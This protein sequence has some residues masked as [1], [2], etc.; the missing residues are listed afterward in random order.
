MKSL[1]AWWRRCFGRAT[2]VEAPGTMWIGG[3]YAEK[4]PAVRPTMALTCRWA[5]ELMGRAGSDTGGYV[6]PFATSARNVLAAMIYAA[7][8]AEV[9]GDQVRQWAQTHSLEPCELLTERISGEAEDPDARTARDQL[10]TVYRDSPAM[11]RNAIM[12]QVVRALDQ[13]HQDQP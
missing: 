11:T 8:T 13:L 9:D 7:Y 3:P 2:P 4:A 10:L 1:F 12:T 5:D 6:E